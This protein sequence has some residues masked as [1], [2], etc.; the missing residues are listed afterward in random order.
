[1]S[2]TGS[3]YPSGWN[4]DLAY[5]PDTDNVVVSNSVS[6]TGPVAITSGSNNLGPNVAKTVIDGIEYQQII[7]D[8]GASGSTEGPVSGY[9][10]FP[11][12][13]GT[14]DSGRLNSILNE[15][16]I[17][18]LHLSHITNEEYTQSDVDDD[19]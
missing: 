11:V 2:L 15:I 18:N 17:M 12:E 7:M 19:I 9:K 3:R 4:R 8:F 13:I 14:D 16:K 6:I 10:R 1:M 5:Y